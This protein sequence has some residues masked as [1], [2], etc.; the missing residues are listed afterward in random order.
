VPRRVVVLLGAWSVLVIGLGSATSCNRN[1]GPARGAKVDAYVVER[2]VPFGKLVGAASEDGSIQKR[3]LPAD[4]APEDA[5]TDLEGM[6]CL[7]AARDLPLG[8]M[9]RRDMF[10]APSDVGLERGL[11]IGTGPTGC[12]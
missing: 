7:V 4:L 5:V 3:P 1:D 8:T 10:V 2:L 9:L 6:R 11:T 12:E